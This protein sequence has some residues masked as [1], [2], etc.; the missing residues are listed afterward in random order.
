MFEYDQSSSIEANSST[1]W[2]HIQGNLHE[3]AYRLP[4]SSEYARAWLIVPRQSGP[5]PF[6]VALHGGG[7]DRDAYLAEARLLAD[8]GVAS[9]LIDLP[10]ARAFPNFSCPDEDRTGL[11]R[12]SLPCGVAWITFLFGLISIRPAARLWVLALAPGSVASL[13]Q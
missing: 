7:Q 8:I 4:E 9:L 13:Q 11:R 12:R 1:V 3:L 2:T 5:S 6:I 10:A